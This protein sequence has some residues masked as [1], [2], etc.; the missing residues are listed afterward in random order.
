MDFSKYGSGVVKLIAKIEARVHDPNSHVFSCLREM[1]IIAKEEEGN[2]L[3]G[4]VYYHYALAYYTRSK[5]K[6]LLRYLKLAISYLVRQ[7]DKDMLAAA[8]NLFAVEAK[9]NGCFE[10]ALDYFLTA[11]YLVEDDKD[12]LAYALT[13]ANI[14]DL[15]AQMGEYKSAYKYV[16]FI[17]QAI[18]IFEKGEDQPVNHMNLAMFHMNLGFLALNSNKYGEALKEKARIE[19]IGI[20]VVRDMGETMEL[21]YLI[22]RLRL[23]IAANEKEAIEALVNELEE[24]MSSSLILSELVQEILDVFDE[25]IKLGDLKPADHLLYTLESK[26]KMNSYARL[27]FSQLKTKYYDVV[28]DRKRCMECYDERFRHL[29]N[30]TETQHFIYYESITLMEML[31]ELRREEEKIRFDNIAIQKNAETDSLTGIPNRYALDRYLDYYFS[32][33]KKN[34]VTLGIGI[35]DIDCFKKYNDTYGHILG[36]QCLIDVARTLEGIAKRHGLSVARYGGDEFVLIYYD[37]Q[38]KEIRAIEKEILQSMSV[39]VTHGFYNAVP[40]VEAKIYDYLSKAD[41]RLYQNKEKSGV[42]VAWT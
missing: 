28:G 25:L 37:L 27:L 3:L 31:E 21:Y 2:E 19:E 10:V 17:R 15:L 30:H 41:Q 39:G 24:R 4:F 12:S 29:Q 36:D 20:S 1:E 26:T 32:E 8:Y 6:E 9:T 5:H 16:K 18:Q 35:V 11:H 13:G 34:Q 14:A 7:D 40:K 33:A 38:S 42:Y 22:F 23:A